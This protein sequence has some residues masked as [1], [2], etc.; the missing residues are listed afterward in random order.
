MSDVVL[1]LTENT[2]CLMFFDNFFTSSL[3]VEN[4]FDKSVYAARTAQKNWG[5]MSEMT[6]DKKMNNNT[7]SLSS[8]SGFLHMV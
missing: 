8:K 1:A 3:R 5:G 2:Y 6:A 7:S 4:L